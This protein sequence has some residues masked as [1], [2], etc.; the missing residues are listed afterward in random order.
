MRDQNDI[1][2]SWKIDDT[3]PLVSII[4]TTFNHENFISET[5]NGFLI[6]KTTFPFEIIVHDD[7]STDNT[8][9]VI[10]DF[11]AKYPLIIKPILQKENQYSKKEVNI[12]SDFTFPKAKGKY[13]A[14]CEG[15][16]YWIDEL[17]LQKQVDFLENN[18]E[19][20]ITWTDFY[21]KKDAELISNDFNSTLPAVY[22]IDFNT[23]FKPYCTYTLTSVFKKDA[24]DPFDYKK[25]EYS[26]DNTLYA[27]ALCNGKGA[28]LNFQGAVYRWHSGGIY[29]L[30]TPFLQRYSSY[31]NLKEIFDK[32]PQSRTQN[33]KRVLETLLKASAF[34]AL[35][36]R[37]N[38]EF[39]NSRDHQNAINEFLDKAGLSLKMKYLWRYIKSN[40]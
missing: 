35:K 37:K 12:W 10:N 28:F 38:K 39:K 7:A 4:C 13:I 31:L 30:Q 17:K 26:K 23:L 34:E 18:T 2:S 14:L 9:S 40:I 8:A 6:Q 36:L 5:L 32:I 25:F 21:T 22:T 20:V 3:Q 16:D 33:I 15:D 27:L 29:S 1:I 24:V 19:Y 11:A